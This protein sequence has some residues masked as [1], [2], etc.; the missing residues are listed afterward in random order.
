MW[1]VVRSRRSKCK[2]HRAAVGR[3]GWR[4]RS[5]EG[6]P[7]PSATHPVRPDRETRGG[8][9][10]VAL[11]TAQWLRRFLLFCCAAVAAWPAPARCAAHTPHTPHTPHEIL[12]SRTVEYG[13]GID[14]WAGHTPHTP[15]YS[16]YSPRKYDEEKW[17]VWRRRSIVEPAM[18]PPAPSCSLLLRT[19]IGRHKLWSM[20]PAAVSGVVGFRSAHMV[21]STLAG[22]ERMKRIA[23]AARTHSSMRRSNPAVIATCSGARSRAE[24]DSRSEA[25]KAWQ[26][27]SRSSRR[28]ARGDPAGR[29]G[30]V[31]PKRARPLPAQA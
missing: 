21:A 11:D 13:T 8:V 27:E 28:R 10:K 1:T 6:L 4:S 18:L 9:M 14:R 30:V 24:G 19:K 5:T 22:P 12:T 2:G 25:K 17:G 7:D 15:P 31:G 26:H 16:P 20:A 23:G 3:G 29:V